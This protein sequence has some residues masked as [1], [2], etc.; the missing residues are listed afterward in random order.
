MDH[1]QDR[2]ATIDM[3]QLADIVA[4]HLRARSL[5][6]PPEIILVDSGGDVI[7]RID[8]PSEGSFGRSWP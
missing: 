7:A 8:L 1:Q 4:A 6:V 3:N 2:L 5:E